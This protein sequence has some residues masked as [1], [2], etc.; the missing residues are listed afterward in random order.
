MSVILFICL[1]A[2]ATA[3]PFSVRMCQQAPT[4]NTSQVCSVETNKQVAKR[5]LS[6]ECITS[7]NVRGLKKDERIEELMTS[8]KR[9]KCFAACIQETWRSGKDVLEHGAA[10]LLLSGFEVPV[11]T[12]GS[13]GVGIVLSSAGVE[14]WKA[15]GGILHNDLGPRVIATRLLVRDCQKRDV[16]IFLVSAY[17]PVG[18]AMQSEWD[19]FLDTLDTCLA[20]ME[21]NDILV[22]G[23]DTNSSMGVS[24]P[25]ENDRHLKSTGQFGM[26]HRNAAGERFS[27]YLSMGNMRA[28]TTFFKKK[29]YATWNHPRSKLPHQIDHII[30]SS[31]DLVKF[32]DAGLTDCLVDS[33]HRA[34]KCSLRIMKRLKKQATP[35]EMLNK[36]DYSLLKNPETEKKLCSTFCEKFEAS[37]A[38]THYSRVASSLN[39][40]AKEVLPTKKRVQPGWFEE[41]Q[42]VILP[43]I[44]ARNEA[45]NAYSS[46]RVTRSTKKRLRE[47]RKKVKTAV[48]EAKN[49]WLMTQCKKLNEAAGAR[50]GTK[51]CWDTVS[52]LKKGLSKVKPAN[53]RM[54][55]KE[56]GTM[57]VSPEENAEVFRKH[58]ETL[59]ERDPSYDPTVLNLMQQREEVGC[60][61][62]PT[63]TEID[64]AIRNLKNTKPGISGLSSQLFKAL[65]A[66]EESATLLRRIVIDFWETELPPDE[67]EKGQLVILPK[68]GD[69]SLPGNHRGIMLLEVAYKIIA[70]ILHGRLLPIEENLDHESQCGFRPG[71]GTMDAI[72]TVKMALKKRREHG[73]ETWIMFLDLVKAFDRVPR[74]LLWGVLRKFGVNEKLVRLLISLH[75]HLE[76]QFT[77]SGITSSVESIIGVKQ[78]DV[79]GPILFTFYL[80][81]VMETWKVEQKRPLCVFRTKE[82]FVLTGR[83]W[84]SAGEKLELPDSEYADDTAVLFCSRQDTEQYAPLLMLHFNRWG[85]EVHSG[86]PQKKSKTE[87]LFASARPQIYEDPDTYDDCDLSPV[88][89]G[90]GNYLPIVAVFQY[91]GSILSRNCQDEEDVEARVDLAAGAFGTLRDCLFS[92]PRICIVAKAIVFEGLVLSILLYGSECWSLTEKCM[93]K[94]RVFIA[95]C[96]RSMNRVTRKHTREYRISNEELRNRAGLLTPDAYVMRHQ[97]RWAGHVSRMNW[98]RLPRKMLSSWVEHKRLVGAPEFTYGRGLM[99]SIRKL[100]LNELNW[101]IAASDKAGWR[102]ICH[103][104]R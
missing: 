30:T 14:A 47:A 102:E 80:A 18:N 23:A 83:S 48:T 56:D 90:G 12:R 55:K 42:A 27:S 45:F 52:L 37:T 89:V 70:I 44:K 76:V 72:F 58:F 62:T 41:E 94:I 69:L 61:D 84:N 49:K 1:L 17:A 15:A 97:L 46:A 11:C 71:R 81:A 68:K 93:N 7:Q 85:L 79:L 2:W 39:E 74:E 24:V 9:R 13:Q 103:S 86:N 101:S 5:R 35:R 77:V 28:V 73:L 51:S 34:V 20:R 25:R 78:G 88:M 33:D 59:Y 60:G 64:K 104:I 99:K 96:L 75:K 50:R 98:N 53:E 65:L 67:W 6:T 26:T 43:L 82:D 36:L 66:E 38:E 100:N 16:F 32:T 3:H 31:K 87:I 91:L 40:A 19:S 4:V 63:V 92:S 22:I 21:H 8:M 54:M 10:R 29:N 57:C 95:R